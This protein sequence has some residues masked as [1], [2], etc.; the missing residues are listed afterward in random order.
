M[1]MGLAGRKGNFLFLTLFLGS[2]LCAFFL[3]PS[4]TFAASSIS[5]Y[6]TVQDPENGDTFISTD[7]LEGETMSVPFGVAGYLQISPDSED[8]NAANAALYKVSADGNTRQLILET[9]DEGTSIVWSEAGTYEVD[10]YGYTLA[11]MRTPMPWWGTV[12]QFF[13]PP[14]AYAAPFGTYV[15]TIRFNIV[16]EGAQP[17][18]A[19]S[20]L[21]LPGFLGSRLYQTGGRLLWEPNGSDDIRD[22]AMNTDGTSK[23][24]VYVGDPVDRIEVNG[25]PIF[26]TIY[27]ELMDWLTTLVNDDKISEW[28][29]YPYDWRYDVFDVVDEGT[30]KENET[31]EYLIDTVEALAENSRTGKVTIIGHSNGGLLA[32]ALLIRLEEQGKEDLIDRLIFVGTPEAGTPQGMLGLLHGHQ[33]VS[34][35]IALN[36]TAR[37]SAVTMPGAYALL[38][39]QEYFLDSPAPVALF[40]VGSVTNS[41][42][43]SLGESIES[44]ATNISFLSNNPQTRIT[45]VQS[46]EETPLPLPSSLLLNAQDTHDELDNWT[47]PIG[48]EVNEIAGWGNRTTVGARYYTETSY[49]C[50]SGISSCGFH[51]SIDFEPITTRDGDNTVVTRSALFQDKGVYFD[52]LTLREET[53]ENAKHE[54]LTETSTIHDYLGYLLGVSESYDEVLFVNEKPNG[55]KNQNI[56]SVHSPVIISLT[57]SEGRKTG[58]YSYPN[59]DLF[60]IREE[61]PD[62]SVH[63][64]GE[65]KYIYVPTNGSYDISVTGIG[66]GTFD[67]V[68]EKENGTLIREFTDLPVSTSTEAALSLENETVGDLSLDI[69]GDGATDVTVKDALTRKD[70]LIICKKEIGLVR[71]LLVKLYLLSMVNNL[72]K[73]G[74]DQ[75]KFTAFKSQFKKY[76]EAQINTIPPAR[77]AGIA[78]CITALE[79]SKK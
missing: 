58:I 66:G 29:A 53:E 22:L 9:E 8:F 31:R 56:V 79:N 36:G 71:T 76:L 17:M 77:R 67:V 69:N 26:G 73:F 14:K 46:D 4:V 24:S 68:V 78:T 72:E 40:E 43:D 49:S 65:S 75:S 47:P 50:P 57:D 45:P 1:N 30:I 60:Y 32:K 41:Y 70:A 52:L 38:P 11:P 21:F 39:S 18:G 5:W 33:T 20:V 54:N 6:Y 25:I 51:N 13:L 61:I 55:S 59:S 35:I 10:V 19:S 37:A 16:E 62:S 63:F 74:A 3:S 34:P 12:V 2:A 23:S 27:G 7:L 42:R 64:G 28:K 15:D 44:F 48:I